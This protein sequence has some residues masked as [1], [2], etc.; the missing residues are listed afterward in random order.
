MARMPTSARLLFN[1]FIAA[2]ILL[3]APAVIALPHVQQNPDSATTSTAATQT[4]PPC[5]QDSHC[6]VLPPKLL[7]AVEAKRPKGDK[8]QYQGNVAVY[9]WVPVNG[10]PTHVKVVEG[11]SE[12]LD[13]AAIEA[14]S[15]MRFQPA[16]LDGKPVKVDLYLDI[17]FDWH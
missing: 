15:K 16:T 5:N 6:K 9:M 1:F 3:A 12:V 17:A 7:H 8:T 4:K 2:F 14:A 13:K 10:I 11:H